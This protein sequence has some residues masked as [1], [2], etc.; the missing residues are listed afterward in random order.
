MLLIGFAGGL[1][2]FEIV[3]RSGASPDGGPGQEGRHRAP[4]RQGDRTSCQTRCTGGRVGFCA[5]ATARR[6]CPVRRPGSRRSARD[7]TSRAESHARRKKKRCSRRAGTTNHDIT[8]AKYRR[9]AAYP[10]TCSSASS[11]RPKPPNCSQQSLIGKTGSMGDAGPRACR[12]AARADQPVGEGSS[13]APRHGPTR[14]HAGHERD[15]G[16]RRR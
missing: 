9:T 16:V 15:L 7:P 4:Q 6:V 11:A 14:N 1:R 2:G 5:E 10:A 3:A 12:A 8:S 13:L